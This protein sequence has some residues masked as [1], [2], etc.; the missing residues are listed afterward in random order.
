F[1]PIRAIVA[2]VLQLP[3]LCSYPQIGASLAAV[4]LNARDLPGIGE[5]FQHEGGGLSDLEAPVRRRELFAST[6]R[7][8]RAAGKHFS[9][10]LAFE[11][12]QLYDQ[13]S[14]ELI[15][16]LAESSRHT[17]TLRILLTSDDKTT[18]EWEG[19]QRVDLMSL[20][21]EDLRAIVTHFA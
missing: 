18:L 14:Q 17:P 6:L 12:Y 19:L 21:D 7:V 2:A 8:L 4:G 3:P 10:V 1:Y 5:L 16:Q 20:L 11:D 13:P 15:V 9:A